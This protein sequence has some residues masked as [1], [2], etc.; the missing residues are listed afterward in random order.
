MEDLHSAA[1]AAVTVMLA[2]CCSFLPASWL[3]SWSTSSRTAFRP[4]ASLRV[5][6]NSKDRASCITVSAYASQVSDYHG[7]DVQFAYAIGLAPPPPFNYSSNCDSVLLCSRVDDRS[8]PIPKLPLRRTDEVIACQ[9]G[10][11][12]HIQTAQ[13]RPQLKCSNSQARIFPD[14]RNVLKLVQHVTYFKLADMYLESGRCMP[15][16]LRTG[17]SVTV[18]MSIAGNTSVYATSTLKTLSLEATFLSK[19]DNTIQSMNQ[20]LNE[21]V[22]PRV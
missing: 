19:F 13:R 14:H 21:H 12:N 16:Q 4:T 1:A 8:A 5:A 3:K 22:M 20:I 2:P 15:K 7:Q 9:A 6:E 11:S 10:A 18:V 17:S